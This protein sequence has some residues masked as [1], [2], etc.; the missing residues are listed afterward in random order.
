V[1]APV[2]HRDGGVVSIRTDVTACA[3]EERRRRPNDG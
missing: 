3:G 2:A 1:I